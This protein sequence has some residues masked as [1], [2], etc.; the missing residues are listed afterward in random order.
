M[1]EETD[2]HSGGTQVIQALGQVFITETLDI[3]ELD[4]N[5]VLDQN[6][7]KKLAGAPA[8]VEDGEGGLG[9]GLETSKTASSTRSVNESG[10]PRSSVFICG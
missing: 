7:G 2:F 3:F 5:R 8:F 1:D 4:H 10:N 9:D 6:I